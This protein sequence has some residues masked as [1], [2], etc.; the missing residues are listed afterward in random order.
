MAKIIRNTNGNFAHY[1]PGVIYDIGYTDQTTNTRIPFYVGETISISQRIGQHRVSAKYADDTS[2]LVYRFI[3]DYLDA[4]NI[5]WD[6]FEIDQY[7]AEGP[8]A[9]E[10]V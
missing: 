5:E 9:L 1:Q 10:D 8:E 4:D 6:L 7:G 3:H 2:T